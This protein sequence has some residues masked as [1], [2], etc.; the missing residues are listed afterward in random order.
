MVFVIALPLMK[1]K[2]IKISLT[3][4]GSSIKRNV[5]TVK[6]NS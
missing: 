6:K 2:I 5:R 3:A 4:K 1:K